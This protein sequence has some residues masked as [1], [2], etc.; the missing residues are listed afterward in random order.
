[1][2]F[3]ASSS[4]TAEVRG[5]TGRALQRISHAMA[6]WTL[7]VH[8]LP[9]RDARRLF[10]CHT[11]MQRTC[12][13]YVNPVWSCAEDLVC[14]GG[15]ANTNAGDREAEIATNVLLF[16]QKGLRCRLSKK[17]KKE[18]KNNFL[19]DRQ[20][21]R[22]TEHNKTAKTDVA[23]EGGKTWRIRRDELKLT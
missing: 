5:G 9:G 3:P 16:E 19:Q 23:V 4:Q 14:C 8:P 10:L 7:Y 15:C 13:K 6:T 22:E 11:D 20:L 1:M 12:V 17:K 2:G 18:T 21:H